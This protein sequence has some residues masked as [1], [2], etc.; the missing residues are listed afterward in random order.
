MFENRDLQKLEAWGNSATG[1]SHGCELPGPRGA[2]FPQEQ[3][4]S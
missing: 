3:S 2:S 4:H 1:L